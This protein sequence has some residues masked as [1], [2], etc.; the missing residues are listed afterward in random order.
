MPHCRPLAVVLLQ[1]PVTL[2]TT[3][4]W[5]FNQ[6]SLWTFPI[7]IMNC[8][9]PDYDAFQKQYG[10]QDRASMPNKGVGSFG[11]RAGPPLLKTDK[12]AAAA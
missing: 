10:C 12:A 1:S 5:C 9:W 8:G 7:L 6:S 2:Q 11:G 4:L 3:G